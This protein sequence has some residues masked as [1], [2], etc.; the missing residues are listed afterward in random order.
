MVHRYDPEKSY[1]W[2]YDHAP[3][4]GPDIEVPEVPGDW[5]FC[6][7]PVAS[8]LGIPA[9]PLLNGAWCLYYARLGFD[10]LTY[11]TVRSNARECYPLPNLVPV[12]VSEMTGDEVVVPTRT[13]M[14]GSWAV[15]FGMPSM[16]PEIWRRDVEQT[17][18][19]LPRGKLLSVSVVGSPAPGMTMEELAADY[20]LCARWAIESGADV[21][22]TNFSC[23]NVSTCDGQLYQESES[24]RLVAEAVR[25]AI[26]GAPYV[27]KIGHVQSD[28]AAHRLIEALAPVIDGLA[29]TNSIATRVADD[30][31]PLFDD[32]PRGICG[33]AI[34][35]A[36]V[37][38]VRRFSRF[39][40]ASG[41]N[42][43]IIGVGGISNSGDVRAY[44]DV[45]ASA[46]QIATAAMTDPLVG[47]R[48]RQELA[49]P[50]GRSS[51]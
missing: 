44:L 45:G 9:G 18:K 13:R 30:G 31:V 42:I 14:N 21:I 5:H 39:I 11:K 4:T 43:E 8:P 23:P 33:A 41:R 10:V 40:D 2:N 20:A 15:S 34:L 24:A 28:P 16:A 6:G 7:L 47:I 32:L 50:A 46:V 48:I 37:G 25:G 26:G 49:K 35:A 38:Q 22:E 36:S 19:K 1:R 27:V 51:G 12:D 29:M 17:R 3:S